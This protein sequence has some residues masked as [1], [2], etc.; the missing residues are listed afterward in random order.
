MHYFSSL[1]AETIPAEIGGVNKTSLQEEM[2]FH[3]YIEKFVSFT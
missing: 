1:A 3:C 2:L